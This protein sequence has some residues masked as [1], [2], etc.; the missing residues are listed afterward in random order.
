MTVALED[1]AVIGRRVEFAYY[2]DQDVYLPG[3]ITALTEDVASLRIRL[4][5]ARSNLAV[6]PDYEHLRYLDEVGPVPDLPM[7]RF[8]PTA[9]DFD[10]EYAGIP[11]V[12]FEE[13]ETVLLTPDNSKARAALAEFAEDMQIAPDYADPAGLVTRSV[14]FEWQPEDAECPWLMD[15]ADADADHAIQIHYLPA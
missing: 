4:D 9:A 13:G 6:R 5:G 11:V 8:T 10:G 7:G 15:F 12:Q 14:V 3:I 2:R 1:K